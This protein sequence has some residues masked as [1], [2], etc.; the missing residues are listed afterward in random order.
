MQRVDKQIGDL[1]NAIR[2][3][4]LTVNLIVVS[5]HGMQKLDG[6]I[7]LAGFADFTGVKVNDSGVFTLV[8]APHAE[9]SRGCIAGSKE[10]APNS[11]CTGAAR[12]QRGH[13]LGVAMEVYTKTTTK[14]RAEAARQLEESVLVN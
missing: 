12:L 1:W 6:F 13:G 3:L 2:G 10:R 11:R 5:D 9:L 7:N 4:N 8:Y 14:A